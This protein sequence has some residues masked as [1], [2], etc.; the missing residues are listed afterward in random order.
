M[1]VVRNRSFTPTTGDSKPSRL[2]RLKNGLPQESLL[3]PLLFIIYDLASI[4]SN[5]YAYADDLAI[6]YSSGDWKVL[7]RTLSEDMTALSAYLQTWRLKLSHAEMVTKAFHLLNRE[8]KCELKVKNN[9]K[10]LLFCPVSTYRGV[11]L[12]RALLYRH[13]IKA[14]REKLF[15]R[16]SLLR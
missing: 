14:L 4:T 10:I 11:K 1:E 6:F 15:T 2:R 8:A 5:K 12:D 9:C 7:E 3:A 13:Y 16:V